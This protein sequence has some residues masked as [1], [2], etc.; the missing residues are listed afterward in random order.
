MEGDDHG[1]AYTAIEQ[2]E[3]LSPEMRKLAEAETFEVVEGHVAGA[4]MR[5]SVVLPGSKTTSCSK[6]SWRNLG[7]LTADRRREVAARIGKA[8]SRSR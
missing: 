7:D 2:G 8:L 5:G 6:G 4:A 1:E 3:R